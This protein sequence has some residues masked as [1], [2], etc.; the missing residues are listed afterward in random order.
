MALGI[1]PRAMDASVLPQPSVTTF[2]GLAGT[3]VS[4]NACSMVAPP[5]DAESVEES[6]AAV[7][8][9]ASSS[10]AVRVVAA[11]AASFILRG[12]GRSPMVMRGFG[13]IR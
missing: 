7:L 4:P 12:K 2:F 13:V 10:A 3:V 1:T 5:A 6:E 8:Q 11:S 9:P